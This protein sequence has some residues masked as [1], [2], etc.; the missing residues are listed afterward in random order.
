[1]RPRS[2]YT[3][4]YSGCLTTTCVPAQALIYACTAV[5]PRV[6]VDAKASTAIV[7]KAWT[8]YVRSVWRATARVDASDIP[9][10]PCENVRKSALPDENRL[11]ERR[12]GYNPRTGARGS[13]DRYTRRFDPTTTSAIPPATAAMPAIGES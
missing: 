9:P 8:K 12:P 1:M 6:G 3:S 10:G 5:S 2:L 4:V 11:R 13:V 7:A